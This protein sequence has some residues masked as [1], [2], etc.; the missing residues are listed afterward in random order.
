M[1]NPKRLLLSFSQNSSFLSEALFPVHT[2]K[3]EELDPSFSL[4]ETI[5]KVTEVEI[6]FTCTFFHMA[7][8][9]FVNKCGRKFIL[10]CEYFECS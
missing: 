9:E 10:S 4:H 5:A 7:K 3:T 6:S 8:S 1:W 2:R